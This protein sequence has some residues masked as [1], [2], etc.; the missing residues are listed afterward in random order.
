MTY[1]DLYTRSED[2]K[3]NRKRTGRGVPWSKRNGLKRITAVSYII[4]PG[5]ELLIY[6][7]DNF[8]DDGDMF[9]LPAIEF[10]FTER[11]VQD[12]YLENNSSILPSILCGFL[13]LAALF[14]IYFFGII[15]ERVYLLF[16]FLL[17]SRAIGG[18]L[19]DTDLFFREDPIT[20]EHLIGIFYF[21]YFF[22]LIHFVR[23]FL[24]TFRAFSALG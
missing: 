7:R 17:L 20:N 2:G 19:Q 1:A 6:E 4:P 15:R 12:Q 24:K 16:S 3:W 14:N 10:G 18:F 11:V 23:Y 21:F 22:F 9:G 5:G 13:L 8:V